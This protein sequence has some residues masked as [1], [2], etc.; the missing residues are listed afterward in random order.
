MRF[1]F[2]VAGRGRGR[3]E[4]ELVDA[5]QVGHRFGRGIDRHPSAARRGEAPQI[6]ETHDVVGV[7]VGHDDGIDFPDVFAQTLGAKIRSGI[8]D[9]GT[10]PAFADRSRHGCDCRA[11]RSN[12]RPRSRNESS[13]RLARCRCR[14][15]SERR[16]ESCQ[17]RV[18]SRRR[19]ESS[20]LISQPSTLNSCVAQSAA[21]QEPRP[22]RGF[23]VGPDSRVLPPSPAKPARANRSS[24]ARSICSLANAPISRSFAPAPMPARS[25]RFSRATIFLP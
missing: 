13:A 11:D 25:R 24:S 17:L 15:R 3:L 6:V 18:E 21:N 14:G 22:G 23:G 7:G 10:P 4:G 2:E 5:L 1:G 8:D 20:S 12:G 9:I 16:V 19:S